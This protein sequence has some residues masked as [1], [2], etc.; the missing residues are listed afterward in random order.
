MTRSSRIAVFTLACC[1]AWLAAAGPHATT[2]ER[3][4]VLALNEITGNDAILGKVK[5]LTAK[6]DDTKKLL[7]AA[8]DLLRDKAGLIGR[9]TSLLLAMVAENLKQPDTA[10]ELYKLHAA[11]ALR[12]SSERGLATAYLGLIQVY[13]DSKRFKDVEQ[14][15]REFLALESEEDDSLDR[16]KPIVYRR[17]VQAIAKQG[18]V[19][20][21]LKMIDEQIKAQ[22]KNWLHV[23]LKAQVLR[24]VERYDDAAK[25]YLDLIDRIGKDK[26]LDDDDKKE[27]IAE[28]RYF[29]SGI[30]TEMNKV[31][32][33]TEQLKTLLAED[34][35]NPTY[36]NDLGFIWA[37]RGMNLVEAERLIRKA[38]AEDK[39]LRR[40]LAGGITPKDDRDNAA[41]LDSL[42]WV[43]FKQG[44][45]KEAKPYLLEAVK[46]P[47]GQ[48][49]EIFDH[50]ADVHLALGETA[51]AIAAWKKGLETATDSRR[52]KKRKVEVEKKLKEAEKKK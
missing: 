47:D 9:N 29:L 34:P 7:A 48:H 32:R 15:C 3:Q 35:S 38:L 49:L 33:A 17:M 16:I 51:E 42:G 18:A 26:N 36:N 41:Y 2:P 39:K 50:L 5:E 8:R 1:A 23:S 14:T 43:L 40:K 19:D 25:T 31:D 21:A 11:Q 46:D 22:P 10:I 37:D 44:K 6:P 24:D 20:R 30:Y 12:M 45:V 28:Y 27:L 13:L 52:D 4:R